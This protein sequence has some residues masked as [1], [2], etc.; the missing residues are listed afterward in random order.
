MD[1]VANQDFATPYVIATGQPHKPTQICKK[2]FKKGDII[3][4][5][6]KTVK[7]KPSFVLHKGVMMIPLSCIKKVVVQDIVVSNL[8]G[9]APKTNPKVEVKTITPTAI[10]NKK[11]IDGVIIGSIAGFAGTLVAE[12]KGWIQGTERKNRIIGAVIGAVI[13][14]YV[15]FKIKK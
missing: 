6:V 5:E 14:C 7:G 2:K 11:Y 9:D 4:G 8:S 12:K 3:T 13:G 1:F 10:K 15:V